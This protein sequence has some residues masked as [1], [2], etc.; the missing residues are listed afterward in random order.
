MRV[1][2]K[3]RKNKYKDEQ[4]MKM[5]KQRLIGVFLLIVDALFFMSG[6]AELTAFIFL[7]LMGLGFIFSKEYVFS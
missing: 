1:R 6:F 3:I 7:G 4:K 2:R 5:L